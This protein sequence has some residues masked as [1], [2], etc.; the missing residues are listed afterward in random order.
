MNAIIEIRSAIEKQGGLKS[1][2][3]KIRK[4]RPIGCPMKV[5]MTKELQ[6]L[7]TEELHAAFHIG[8]IGNAG[9]K[10]TI[11]SNAKYN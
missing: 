6:E 5:M 1:F 11:I 8:L 3:S 7:S 2:S 9:K 10:G 4:N